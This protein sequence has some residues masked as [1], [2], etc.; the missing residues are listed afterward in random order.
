MSTPVLLHRIS[1]LGVGI[2][3][4]ALAVPAGSFSAEA[5]A[6]KRPNVILVLTDDQGYPDL[7]CHGNPTIKTPNLDKL[8]AESVRLTDFHVCPCC[9]LTRAAL[10][11]G[12]YPTRT[13]VWHTVLG[14]SILHHGEVTVAEVFAAAG[15]RTAM[16]GKWH[17]GDNYPSRP[18][19]CGFQEALYHG[20][21]GVGNTQ[22]YW[23]N[24]YFDDTYFRNGKPER[25]TGYCT[26]VWFDEASKFIEANRRRPFFCYIATN[27]PHLP[28]VVP[29][30]YSEPYSRQGLSPPLAN[31][32]GMITN[33]DDNIAR[34]RQRLRQLGIERNTILVFATDNGTVIGHTCFKAGMRGNKGSQYDGGHRVPCFFYWPDGGLTGGRD[35]NRLTAHVDLLPTLIELCGLERAGGPPLDGTSL[36][37]LLKGNTDDWPDRTLFVDNQRVFTPVKWRRTAVMTDHWRLVDGRELYDIKQD[38]GQERDVAAEHPQVVEGLRDRYDRWWKNIAESFARYCEITL[39][40]GR[41]NPTVLTSHDLHGAAVWNHDQVLAGKRCDGFWAVNVARDGIYEISLRRWPKEADAPIT[42]PIAIPPGLRKL[43]YLSRGLDYALRAEQ[44]R[45]LPATYARLKIGAFDRSKIIPQAPLDTERASAD[46]EL[47]GQGRV[48][49]VR[50]R[51]PLAT[52]STRLQAWFVDGMDNGA[53]HGAYYVYVKRLPGQ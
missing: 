5:P 40:S 20:G 2:V 39:G 21:G 18:Q 33:I 47:D 7:A 27:A 50:F 38:P 28:F 10:M 3:A 6:G 45:V 44:G 12:R 4:V 1:F 9:S 42:G 23:A 46:Y 15:Y 53:T 31:F 30:Q 36:V 41:D 24:D 13:G 19:D 35:V 16:F 22:D 29:R 17:L 51:A 48:T 8:Y 37:P 26:D 34:L 49:A 11:T 14:R 43:T 52:G 25:F 32:Y